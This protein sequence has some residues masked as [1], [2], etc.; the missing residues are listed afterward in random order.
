MGRRKKHFASTN[1]CEWLFMKRFA[2]INFLESRFFVVFVIDGLL[3]TVVI[4]GLGSKWDWSSVWDD[5]NDKWKCCHSPI[6]NSK[7]K[8]AKDT[9]YR[10]KERRNS[11]DFP[12]SRDWRRERSRG[13]IAAAK[14]ATY[15]KQKIAKFWL[16]EFLLRV[17][18]F[19][20]ATLKNISRVFNFVNSTKIWE[21]REN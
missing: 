16:F 9:S 3:Q 20:I 8:A 17:I 2:C 19:A 12:F 15:Q 11:C 13:E 5:G 21:N 6:F 18:I 14:K 10:A 7:W 4:G 1:F